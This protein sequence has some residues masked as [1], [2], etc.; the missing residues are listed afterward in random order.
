MTR[1]TNPVPQFLDGNG[2][3]YGNGLMYFYE[4]GT[5]T[6]KNTFADSDETIANTNPV[7][8][9]AAG[10]IPN[11][12]FTGLARVVLK[13]AD[14]VQV[15]ER[16]LVGS[17][18]AFDNF[19][20][21]QSF[22]LYEQNDFVYRNGLLYRSLIA[23]NQGNDP[24]LTPSSNVNWEEVRFVGTYNGAITYSAGDIVRTTTGSVWKSLVG[25]NSGNDPEKDSGTNWIPA[26]DGAKVPEIIAIAD[27]TTTAIALSGGGALT[28]LRV[29]A[30]TD[31]NTYT[32][33][34]ASSVSANQ[35]VDVELEDKFS[36]QQPTVQRSGSD[37]I[38][39]SGVDDTDILFD[40]GT[41]IAI[42][43][44]SDGVNR[45]RF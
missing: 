27:R 22:V 2:D 11:V 17:G 38:E 28:A 29:N 18:D 19:S 36:A 45:W 3:P 7:E 37:L 43:L 25:N 12:W 42:R 13:T 40:T 39:W 34:L 41:S 4:A 14:D 44:Y 21:W 24:A 1:I 23:S 20:E 9:D 33:P 6:F 31:S 32:L 15:W 10:R 8:L 16:D 26:L 5:N 30:L 35:F